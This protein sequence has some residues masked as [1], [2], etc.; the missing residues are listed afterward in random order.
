MLD[1]QK[2]LE[3]YRELQ[4]H[5]E[6]MPVGLPPTESGI[7]L[8]V[9]QH[10]FSPEEAF[11]ATKLGALPESVEKIHKRFQK[12]EMSLNGLEKKLDEMYKK[13]LLLRNEKNGKKFRNAQLVIGM[14]EFQVNRMSKEYYSDMKLYMEEAFHKELIK[15]NIPTQ[16]RTIPIEKSIPLE[17]Q[18]GNYDNIRELVENCEGPF[19]VA[20]CLCKQ[21]NQ[22]LG[23]SCKYTDLIECCITL[24]DSADHTVDLGYSRYISRDETL[25]ILSKAQKEGLVLQ[26]ENCQDPQYICACCGDCCGVLLAAK[27]YERPAEYYNSN[28][29]AEISSILCRGCGSCME[30]CH[31]EALSLKDNNSHVNLDR[32][33]GCGSCVQ[34]CPSD[35]IYLKKKVDEVIPPKNRQ[36]LYKKIMMKKQGFLGSLK[37]VFKMLF[38]MRI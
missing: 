17:H 4:H 18:I 37:M 27:Q 11:I 3:I 25:E 26:P 32:C 7:E 14:H 5:L 15:K 35:A 1:M 24:N 6:R 31:M 19:A 16:I 20:N 8:K 23:N 12:G 22:L 33:I 28:F 21:G 34:I 9:L 10:L 13:G 38:G 36:A 2:D 30:L 29:Y